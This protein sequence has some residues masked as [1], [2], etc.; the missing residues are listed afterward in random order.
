[1]G[2]SSRLAMTKRQPARENETLS[3]QGMA[4]LLG[5]SLK[6]RPARQ[7]VLLVGDVMLTAGVDPQLVHHVTLPPVASKAQSRILTFEFRP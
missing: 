3:F 5:S 6:G 1:M 4:Y 2:R 7:Y